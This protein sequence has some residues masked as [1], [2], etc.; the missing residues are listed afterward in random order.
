MEITFDNC[1]WNDNPYCPHGKEKLT[2]EYKR[3]YL[4]IINQDIPVYPSEKQRLILCR[5]INKRYCH[6]CESFEPK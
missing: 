6:R 5:R 4:Y 3:D 1:K 2:R